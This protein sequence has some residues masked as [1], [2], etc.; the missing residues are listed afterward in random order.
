MKT[1]AV[2][3][4]TYMKLLEITVLKGYGS[5]EQTISELIDIATDIDN[6]LK[7]NKFSTNKL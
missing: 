4:E 5:V 7:E 1:L 6:S 3:P 2:N